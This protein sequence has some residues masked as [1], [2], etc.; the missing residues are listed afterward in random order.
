MTDPSTTYVPG[1]TFTGTRYKKVRGSTYSPMTDDFKSWLQSK[2]AYYNKTLDFVPRGVVDGKYDVGVK[3]ATLNQGDNFT[4]NLVLSEQA[5]KDLMSQAKGINSLD[6][7]DTFFKENSEAFQ[8]MEMDDFAKIQQDF[9][10]KKS[11]F[12]EALL[13]EQLKDEQEAAVNGAHSSNYYN[14]SLHEAVQDGKY[15]PNR[16]VGNVMDNYQVPMYYIRLFVMKKDAVQ[17]MHANID[18]SAVEKIAYKITRPDPDDIVVIAETGATDLT[19]DDLEIEH[20]ADGDDTFAT[21][22]FSWQITEPGSITLLDRLAAARNFCGYTSGG[23]GSGV[24][25]TNM[26][27]PAANGI[28]YFL[29]ISLK[30]YK[31]DV[32]NVDEGDGATT[33]IMG[34]YIHELAYLKFDMTIGPEGAVYNF[35]A[36]PKDNVG[37]FSF[38]N[39]VKS[40]ITVTGNNITGLLESLNEQTNSAIKSVLEDKVD[41]VQNIPTYSFNYDGLVKNPLGSEFGNDLENGGKSYE[42]RIEI[43][44]SGQRQEDDTLRDTVADGYIGDDPENGK[45]GYADSYS[46]DGIDNFLYVDPSRVNAENLKPNMKDEHL[47][48]KVDGLT[49]T[50]KDQ[51]G[52]EIEYGTQTDPI[53]LIDENSENN[54]IINIYKSNTTTDET[55]VEATTLTKEDMEEIRAV[56]STP[57]FVTITFTEG[58][59]IVDCINSIMS[60]SYDLI[61]KATRLKNPE[62]PDGDVDPEKTFVNWF[63]ITETVNYDYDKYDTKLQ[64][65]IP[66]I[67]YRIRLIKEARTDIGISPKELSLTLTKEQLATRIQELGIA[68]EYLY[69]FTGLND[70]IITLDMSFNEAFALRTPVFGQRD[71]RAA[72][73][74]ATAK[75]VT[76][77]EAGASATGEGSMGLN[78][79]LLTENKKVVKKE[80]AKNFLNELAG[81]LNGEGDAAESLRGT[82]STVADTFYI[83]SNDISDVANPNY[84]DGFLSG[85]QVVEAIANN[86]TKIT[87]KFAEQL[88]QTD[89]GQQLVNAAL[90]KSKITPQAN[91]TTSSDQESNTDNINPREN[92]PLFA[93][94][95]FP[96]LE[97]VSSDPRIEE[98]YAKQLDDFIEAKTQVMV[99]TGMQADVVGPVAEV[100]R[101][102]IRSTSFNHL[103]NSHRSGAVS[104]MKVDLELRGDPWFMG[105]GSFYDGNN[106]EGTENN[107]PIADKTDLQGIAYNSGS[108]Q[109]LLM[110]ESPRKLDF[111]IDDEDQNTGFFNYGHL[112]YTMSGVYTI[113]RV[114]SKFSGGM[115]TNDIQGMKMSGYETSK[116]A[117]VRE[118]I[119]N[120]L[121]QKID[122]IGDTMG[123]GSGTSE[124]LPENI[125]PS[126]GDT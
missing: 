59:P 114:M 38:L 39:R 99:S 74:Y 120:R 51:F 11:G 45:V 76:L 8:F 117:K 14:N 49:G 64:M 109:F 108:N 58:T 125:P 82:L 100:E 34:P 21:T 61:N 68:K 66:H 52:N 55:G 3:G 63:K 7:Y 54:E 5:A 86:N 32:D 48:P 103:M 115:Y 87:D 57:D 97:G 17:A 95:I 10:S 16:V 126:G 20:F 71:F 83:N 41:S 18:D 19:I 122:A 13:E 106:D 78:A 88:A 69:Y 80:Q 70:Q 98:E 12:T 101:G 37:R 67:E 25:A 28:P 96:G 53:D 30:G 2:S 36:H 89:A 47:G 111:N 121:Q 44:N 91:T 33:D 50:Y 104:N 42:D 31:D 85:D 118:I 93:S 1:Q 73:A 92:V 65:Y 90:V 107:T 6:E 15:L 22:S 46:P 79:S 102:S 113:T 29:E 27:V 35:S 60:L 4:G 94:E 105:K 26:G 84:S 110:I 23:A 9:E 75:D 116:L 81:V 40:Q 124:D 112:N 43:Y 56:V 119:S 123:V 24:S 77:E 62:L 72:M